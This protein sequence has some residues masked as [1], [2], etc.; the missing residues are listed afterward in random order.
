MNHWD[1]STPVAPNGNQV[2]G[3]WWQAMS[4]PKVQVSG[5]PEV[6]RLVEDVVPQ[7]KMK[8]KQ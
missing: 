6:A 3:E 2:L 8:R 4:D 1:P 5:V 7:S